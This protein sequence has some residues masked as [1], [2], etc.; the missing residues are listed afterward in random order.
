MDGPRWV[1][2]VRDELGGA[3]A[4][5]EAPLGMIVVELQRYDWFGVASCR[6]TDIFYTQPKST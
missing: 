3:V 5:W 6:P 4:E 1:L 2:V